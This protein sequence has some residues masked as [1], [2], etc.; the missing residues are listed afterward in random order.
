M[1]NHGGDFSFTERGIFVD[2][3]FWMIF[4]STLRK[5]ISHDTDLTDKDLYKWI[6]INLM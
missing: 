2:Y 5:R 1:A 3:F 6:N 4:G